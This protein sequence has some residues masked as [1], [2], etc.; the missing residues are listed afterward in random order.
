VL[1]VQSA[2]RNQIHKRHHQQAKR[3][4]MQVVIFSSPNRDEMLANVVREFSGYDI[5]II[6]DESTFGID[7]FW[8]R[9]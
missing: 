1:R 3:N 2:Q 4:L 9:S 8:Q 5:A 7:K 6:A